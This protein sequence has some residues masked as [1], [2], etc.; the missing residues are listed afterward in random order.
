[1][2]RMRFAAVLVAGLAMTGAA[3]SGDDYSKAEFQRDLEEEADLSPE[4]AKC[5]ADGVDDAGIDISE[6]NTD[7]EMDEVLDEGE[8][9][10]FTEAITACVMDDAG[11]DPS[12]MSI[13]D[14]SDLTVPEGN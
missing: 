14:A 4:V 13:P 3:C 10:K 2:K 12:D 8:Q 7:K 9:E 5:V 11:I 6:F 1:M